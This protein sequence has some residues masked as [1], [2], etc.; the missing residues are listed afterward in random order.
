[1]RLVAMSPIVASLRACLIANRNEKNI[2]IRLPLC[3]L[4]QQRLHGNV[5]WSDT[6]LQ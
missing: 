1:M 2:Q 5:I 3:D 6:R 4:G